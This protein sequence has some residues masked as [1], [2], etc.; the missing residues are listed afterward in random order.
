[1][2][3]HSAK[4]LGYDDHTQQAMSALGS[5]F[6]NLVYTLDAY[7]DL[8]Q[9]L[10]KREFNAFQAL[11]QLESN[12]V[13]WEVYTEM[14][15]HLHRRQEAVE[16]A[17]F[18]LPLPKMFQTS[19]LSRLR[20]NMGRRLGEEASTCCTSQPT[21]P[22]ASSQTIPLQDL[23]GLQMPAPALA[24]GTAPLQHLQ[25]GTTSS[26]QDDAQVTVVRRRRRWGGPT[27]CEAMCADCACECCCDLA[28]C[29]MEACCID[30]A[31]CTDGVCCCGS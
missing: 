12:T 28:C 15:E 21:E 13:S 9:D 11:Y 31:C 6:G 27:C 17:I 8:E 29:E 24:T 16:R 18:G 10:K 26:R 3:Q 19:F 20:S 5:A 22:L 23:L 14:R 1:M 25:R 30:A 7:E 2:F 4:A